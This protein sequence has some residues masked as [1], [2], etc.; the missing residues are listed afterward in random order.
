MILAKDKPELLHP[1][2]SH[3]KTNKEINHI[4]SHVHAGSFLKIVMHEMLLGPNI[5]IKNKRD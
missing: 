3:C 4:K 5:N 1:L 2:V